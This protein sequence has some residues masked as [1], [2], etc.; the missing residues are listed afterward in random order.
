[1]RVL[2]PAPETPIQRVMMALSENVFGRLRQHAPVLRVCDKLDKVGSVT[3][4]GVCLDTQMN[5]WVAL[6][7][8]MASEHPPEWDYEDFVAQTDH[9]EVGQAIAMREDQWTPR[10]PAGPPN[11]AELLK[12]KRAVGML[13]LPQGVEWRGNYIDEMTGL[14]MRAVGNYMPWIDGFALRWDVLCG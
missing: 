11:A 4:R 13:F 14:T 10:E 5:A 1:M 7:G 6:E 8:R 9:W 3:E 2:G 12:G